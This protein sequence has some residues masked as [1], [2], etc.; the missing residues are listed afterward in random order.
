[1]VENLVEYFNVYT[2]AAIVQ[3][4]AI[5]T[6]FVSFWAKKKL[7]LVLTIITSV[8]YII[9]YIL[10]NAWS[11][12]IFAMITLFICL[13]VYVID[14]KQ[15]VYAE[16]KIRKIRSIG[17]IF[18]VGLN[19]ILSIITDFTLP[20]ILMILGA[21]L[22]YYNYFL[23]K[24]ND[25]KTKIIFIFSHI[26]IIVYEWLYLLY[27]FAIMEFIITISILGSLIFLIKE[28][29]MNKNKP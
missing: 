9:G 1:M 22:N 4:C 26:L 27:F 3:C 12:L 7:F 14:K 16:N 28:E 17:F 21:T 18:A 13:F 23:M 24:E 6:Y 19:L 2:A 8:F 10:M 25:K 11:G 15:N 29:R 5:P 20:T